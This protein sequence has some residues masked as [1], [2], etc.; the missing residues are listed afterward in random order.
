MEVMNFQYVVTS[1]RILPDVVQTRSDP[2]P[3]GFSCR[4]ELQQSLLKP[5]KAPILLPFASLLMHYDYHFTE[6]ARLSTERLALQPLDPSWCAR[7]Q[8][9]ESPYY[10]TLCHA[11]A[12]TQD[13]AI[14]HLFHD[15][16]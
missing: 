14:D 12:S 10:S 6:P 5:S 16:K 2:S 15:L 13:D 1:Y 3:G 9:A 8:R 4:V 7:N 11:F